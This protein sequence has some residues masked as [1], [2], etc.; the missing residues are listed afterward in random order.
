MKERMEKDVRM[1]DEF[2][3][4]AVEENEQTNL[5]PSRDPIQRLQT[6]DTNHT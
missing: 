3:A 2:R 6:R 4:K 5:F 1:A